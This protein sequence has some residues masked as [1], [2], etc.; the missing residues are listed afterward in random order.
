[1][2]KIITLIL[3][4]CTIFSLMCI[5]AFAD[6][7]EAQA[8]TEY[9]VSGKYKFNETLN[10]TEEKYYDVPNK[11]HIEGYTT[12]YE[13]IQTGIKESGTKYLYYNRSWS[14]E[15]SY[16]YNN[17]WENEDYRIIDFGTEEQTISEELYNFLSTNAEKIEN[18][19]TG[20]RL[21]NE[22]LTNY[23]T[24]YLNVN[25]KFSNTQTT[26]TGFSFINFTQDETETVLN[27][28]TTPNTT[29]AYNYKN[30][31]W[32]NSTYRIVDFGEGEVIS[33]EAYNWIINNSK[34]VTTSEEYELGYLAGYEAGYESGTNESFLSDIFGFLIPGREN[35]TIIEAL[36]A[37][38][39]SYEDILTG[40]QINISIMTILGTLAGAWVTLW[41]LKI[42]AGH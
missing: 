11:F 4:V 40:R 31:T 32:T 29:E 14:I 20:K 27:Y 5:T 13:G 25:F 33:E 36:N 15:T 35:T 3:C 9:K 28:Q 6:E 38:L 24:V 34:A 1:M 39:F 19:V 22:T 7:A 16:Q 41:F 2:K 42:F 12:E 18:K 23:N 8:E 30:N 10:I 17:K 37:P 21:M 26:A